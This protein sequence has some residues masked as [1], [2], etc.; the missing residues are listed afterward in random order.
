M[1]CFV[2]YLVSGQLN[3]H[4]GLDPYGTYSYVTSLGKIAT[5]RYQKEPVNGFIVVKDP[6]SNVAVDLPN[7]SV[8][9]YRDS[10]SEVTYN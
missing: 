6:I 9:Q 10:L 8:G 1:L 3:T 4:N 2:V 7:V 5:V